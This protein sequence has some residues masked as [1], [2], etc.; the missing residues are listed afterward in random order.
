MI[1]DNKKWL[2]ERNFYFK[3]YVECD[4][5]TEYFYIV[6]PA[7]QIIYSTKDEQKYDEFIDNLYQRA[8]EYEQNIK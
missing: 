7:G 2:E 6:S 5:G 1:K 3:S 8:V 4:D